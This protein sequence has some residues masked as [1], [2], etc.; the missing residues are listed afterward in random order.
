MSYKLIEYDIDQY[1]IDNDEVEDILENKTAAEEADYIDTLITEEKNYL[2]SRQIEVIEIQKENIIIKNDNINDTF[3]QQIPIRKITTCDQFGNI[4]D[5]R[6][7]NYLEIDDKIQNA[8]AKIIIEYFKKHNMK[9]G[10]YKP[11]RGLISC[12]CPIC[13][14]DNDKAFIYINSFFIGTHSKSDCTDEKHKKGYKKIQK[15]LNDLWKNSKDRK[16]LIYTGDLDHINEV[17]TVNFPKI[18]KKNNT[19]FMYDASLR[20]YIEI[21]DN[22]EVSQ[23]DDLI[24]KNFFNE[25]NSLLGINQLKDIKNYIKKSFPFEIRNSFESS[26]LINCKNGVLDINTMELKDHSDKYFFN[27]ISGIKYNPSVDDTRLKQFIGNVITDENPIELFK[28]ILGHIHFDGAKLQKGFIFFGTKHGRNGKGTLVKLIEKVIG[29]HRTVS[30]N[31]NMFKESSFA[32]YQLK[33]K[34]LYIEDD[35]KADYIDAK[36]IGLLNRIVSGAPD[37]VHQ[38]NKPAMEITHTAVPI[39]QCN[40]TPKLKAED[41]GGFYLRWVVVNFKNEYG[42]KMDEFLSVRLMEDEN[43]LSSLLNYMIDGVKQIID[44]KNNGTIGNFFKVDEESHIKDWKKENNSVLQFVDECCEI[45]N[46]YECS[47]RDLYYYY[48]DEWNVGGSKMSEKKFST[49]ITDELDVEKNRKSIKG[50]KVMMF[51][52]LKCTDE[53]CNNDSNIN[54]HSLEIKVNP[55]SIL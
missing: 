7:N 3:F 45:N 13:N 14:K 8:R 38:K 5:S 51:K 37:T 1:I 44:R 50:K 33:D 40:K 35:Y 32:A 27:Y 29:S 54:N 36:T 34:A 10:M 46:V 24:Y 43:V 30:M 20:H 23:L 52:G 31:L 15:D 49:I 28:R 42:N 21:I 4:L 55:N 22:S 19:L 47:V 18:I 12:S 41:D 11:D 48:R 2:Q 16:K 39:I 25:G 9:I 17:V 53:A 26:M 6:Y